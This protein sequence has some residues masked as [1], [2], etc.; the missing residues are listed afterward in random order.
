MKVMPPLVIHFNFKKFVILIFILYF[1]QFFKILIKK[2]RGMALVKPITC[3]SQGA[4]STTK[5]CGE[6][7]R[8]VMD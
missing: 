2:G 4:N 6:I 1:N 3:T 5:F 7:S 8:V